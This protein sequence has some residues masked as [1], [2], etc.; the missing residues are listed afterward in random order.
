MQD[1]RKK[2]LQV[3]YYY[4]SMQYRKSWESFKRKRG[5]TLY[6]SCRKLR[7]LANE[8]PWRRLSCLCCKSM[9]REVL[10]FPRMIAKL[11]GMNMKQENPKAYLEMEEPEKDLEN[12]LLQIKETL[13]DHRHVILS[14]IFKEKKCLEERIR[15]FNI[16]CVLDEKT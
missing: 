10:D 14:N 12:V 4:P 7:H 1:P 11:E 2:C 8:F 3:S 6:Y 16:D 9:D 13:N 5:L 15:D